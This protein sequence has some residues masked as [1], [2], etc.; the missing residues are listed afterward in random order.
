MDSLEMGAVKIGRNYGP[1]HHRHCQ[2]ALKRFLTMLVALL[3][4]WV[5]FL[6]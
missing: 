3:C 1:D 6:W 2:E 4:F 5:V